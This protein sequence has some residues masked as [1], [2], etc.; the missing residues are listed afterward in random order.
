MIPKLPDTKVHGSRAIVPATDGGGGA[1]KLGAFWM[2]QSG[3]IMPENYGAKNQTPIVPAG[4][5][6]H[7]EVMALDE[8]GVHRTARF[9]I[10]ER[11]QVIPNTKNPPLGDVPKRITLVDNEGNRFSGDVDITSKKLKVSHS[12]YETIKGLELAPEPKP[13]APPAGEVT[14]GNFMLT[15]SGHAMPEN[16]AAKN[17]TPLVAPGAFERLEVTALDP[18]GVH[19]TATY[20]LDERGHLV[21]NTK[22]PPLGDLP[23]RLTLVDADG[24]RYQGD[25]DISSKKLKVSH[26]GYETLKNVKLT[27]VQATDANPETLNG[28]ARDFVKSQSAPPTG[29]KTI[30]DVIL[31]R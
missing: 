20:A 6:D 18:A 10:D 11:G 4:K 2:T 14:L 17:Q 7:I 22:N 27:L 26:Q 3:N 16:Y 21:P 31:R 30:A 15:Q 9:E 19:R 8:S 29:S 5:F 1:L 24:N 23:Y 28:V 25:I 13:K 12:G